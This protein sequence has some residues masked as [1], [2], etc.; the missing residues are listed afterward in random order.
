VGN[1]RITVRDGVGVESGAQAVTVN[2]KAARV[3]NRASKR[4]VRLATAS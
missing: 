4:S 1:D 3:S 2:E